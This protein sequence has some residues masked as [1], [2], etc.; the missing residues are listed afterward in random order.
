MSTL[1]SELD[2]QAIRK[3]FPFLETGVAY[4]D[5]ANTSQRP[6]QVFAAMEEYFT[7][8]NANI[9]RAAYRASEQATERYEA[10]RQKARR[11]LNARSQRE[12]I[13]TRGTTEGINLVAYTWGR[14]NIREGD[15]IVLT[16]L[17]HHSNIVPW[18]MLAQEKGARLAYVDIDEAGELR[19]DQFHAL[20]EQRPKLVAF[21][22][23]SNTLGTINPYVGMTAAAKAAGAVVLIDGAQGAPH[24][25]IDVQATDC[26]FYAFSSHKMCGP[27]GIGIL[28]GR[29]ELLEAMPPFM[30]GGDMIRAVHLQTTEYA[31][32]PE[33]FEAGT[34][35]IAEAI[36]F[37]TALDYVQE[38]GLD[39]IHAH[40]QEL[41][42]YALEALSEIPGL[43]VFGPPV[44]RRAG[45]ISM[46]LAGVHPHDLAT[47]LDRHDVNV[48][49][50]HNCTMP[51]MQRL[52]V[53][54][55]ARASFYLYTTKDEIDR[56]V[57][58]LEDARRIFA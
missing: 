49:S 12:V 18:Q 21:T 4:L 34:Q 7:K 8:Y 10:T 37:G 22:Q 3:D 48:R 17:E 41:T 13:Y 25:G 31:P 28:Y 23:V 36:G 16:I 33:K 32:L 19:M 14:Q 11:F 35:P 51:L 9:H 57:K 27:T 43:R 50:G 5:S 15:L 6:R 40:E 56:L 29:R 26:D 44:E 53:T 47:I 2:V 38:I 54:A 58:G 52:D 30:G 1:R 55:T 24:L 20:L 46:D 39:A 42:E 45:V